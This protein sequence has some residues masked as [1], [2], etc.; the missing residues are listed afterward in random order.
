MK[1]KS[2]TAPTSLDYAILGMVSHEP[3]SGYGI[4]K[5]FETT[6]MGNYSNSPGTIY[7]ALKRMQRFALI[8]A[9]LDKGSGK[10]KFHITPQGKIFLRKW[11][12][13]PLELKDVARKTDEIFLRFAFMDTL[14]S[15]REKFIFLESFRNLLTVYVKQ[16]KEY[17]KKECHNMPLHGRL[18]FEHGIE[19]YKTTLKWCRKTLLLLAK[20]TKDEI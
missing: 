3:L 5:V 15:Q 1:R 12:V 8:E 4:R 13:K 6:A 10:S 16:L 14:S 18:A 2:S 19:S 11:L 9:L 20:T 7:P 17:H